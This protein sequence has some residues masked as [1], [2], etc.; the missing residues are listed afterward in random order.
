MPTGT[1]GRSQDQSVGPG[2]AATFRYV[3]VT[4]DHREVSVQPEACQCVAG[5]IPWTAGDHSQSET[6]CQLCQ[7]VGFDQWPVVLDQTIKIVS[8]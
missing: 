2:F 3:I 7:H 5:L 6:S 1:S 4:D 8:P